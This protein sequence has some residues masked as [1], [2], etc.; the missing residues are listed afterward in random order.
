MAPATAV[1]NRIANREG[2]DASSIYK[3]IEYA[4][5]IGMNSPDPSVKAIWSTIPCKGDKPT[6]DEL[7]VWILSQIV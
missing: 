3:E 2:V 6:V 7:I 4:M 5:E 1:I